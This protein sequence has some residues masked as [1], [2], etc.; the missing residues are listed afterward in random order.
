MEDARELE[1]H[2]HVKGPQGE[3]VVDVVKHAV[4]LSPSPLTLSSVTTNMAVCDARC[5]V[6]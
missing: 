4:R 6:G 2:A 1:G 5:H 3:V